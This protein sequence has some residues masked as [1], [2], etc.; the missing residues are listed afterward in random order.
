MGSIL[1]AIQTQFIYPVPENPSVLPGTQVGRIVE[2]TGKKKVVGFQCRLLDPR[3]QGL[4]S[5]SRNLELHWT[6]G[7]VLHDDGSVGH[8]IAMGH[9]ADFE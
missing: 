3:L 1:R 9:V 5:N 6:L 7:L 8:L 4:S 2:S